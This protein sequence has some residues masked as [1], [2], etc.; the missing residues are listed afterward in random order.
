MWQRSFVAMSVLVG[1]TVDDA[2]GALPSSDP[3]TDDLVHKMRDPRKVV[4]ATALAGAARE[5]VVAID[6][7][8]LR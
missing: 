1:S 7:M 8:T 4:R 5:V 2:V 3:P 6:R